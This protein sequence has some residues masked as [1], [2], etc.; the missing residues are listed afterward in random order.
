MPRDK[1]IIKNS[2]GIIWPA[3]YSLADSES[4]TYHVKCSNLPSLFRNGGNTFSEGVFVS[5]FVFEIIF[6][7]RLFFPMVFH[8]L[9]VSLAA[10]VI[11]NLV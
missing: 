7:K 10:K 11:I 4:L 2:F 6:H 1:Q 5:C 9:I 8:W 3:Y